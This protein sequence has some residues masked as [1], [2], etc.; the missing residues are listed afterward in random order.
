[1]ATIV[2]SAV[3]AA[4]GS[5]LLPEGIAILG[6]TITGATIGS[7]IGGS[8]GNMIDQSL[9]AGHRNIRT[10][11]PRQS[12]LR[13]TGSTEG[14]AVPRLFGRMRTGGQIIWATRFKETASTTSQSAGGKGFGG[15]GTTVTQTNYSYSISFAI[16]LC[17]GPISGI[18]RVWADGKPLDLSRINYRLH[19]GGEDQLPD[20]TIEA[21]E[22][23]NATPAYRGL[24][25]LVFDDLALE[26]FGNRVPQISVEVFGQRAPGGVE[27][28]IR[29]VDLIPASGEFTYATDL[30]TRT[31]TGA[32]GPGA[33]V[34]GH[35]EAENM[36]NSIGQPDIIVALDQLEQS[37]PNCKAVAL[38]ISWFGDDLR[39]GV[40]RV[41]PGVESRDKL[42]SRSWSVA[43]MT[44]GSAYLVTQQDGRAI[45][46]GTPSDDT[47]METIA[48][49]KKRGIKIVFYPFI[50]MDIPPETRTDDP[51]GRAFQPPY[52][53]RGRITCMPAP[54]QPATVDGTSAAVAD[55]EA[56][57]WGGPDNWNFAHMIGHYASLCAQAGGVDAFLVGSEL[58]GLT[59]V[60]GPG[61]SYPAVGALRTL[62]ATVKGYLPDTKVSYAADWTEWNNHQPSD[63][64][65]TLRFHLDPLWS[66]PVIDFIAIDN[67][68]PLSDWRDGSDHLDALAGHKSLY[69]LSYLKANVQGGERYDWY[70]ASPADRDAQ[71]RTPITD[72]AYGKPWVYRPKDLWNWWQQPHFE[73]TGGIEHAA[74]TSWVPESKPIVLTE[75]GCPAIDKGTNQP[76][77]FVDPKSS[78][79]FVPYYSSGRRDDLIQ[80]RYI[81]A[82]TQ[83]FLPESGLN[84]VSSVYGGRMIPDEGIFFWCWDARPFPDFPARSEIW[85]DTINWRL[86]HWLTGRMGQPGIGPV[87]EALAQQAGVTGNISGSIASLVS[88]YLIDRIMSPRQALETLMLAYRFD[89]A[90]RDG[91]FVLLPRNIPPVM[92]IKAEDLVE[93]EATDDTKPGTASYRIV[94]KQETDL[95][96]VAKLSYIDAGGDYRRAAAEVRR[97]AGTAARV[98]TADFALV[99]DSGEAEDIA[100]HMLTEAWGGREELTFRLP[101]TL[102]ALEPGDTIMF[103]DGAISRPFRIERVDD[104]ADRTVTLSAAELEIPLKPPAR[105][106]LRPT[107]AIQ[108]YAPPVA[109]ILDLPVLT[110]G[111]A[112]GTP[113][114]AAFAEPWPGGIAFHR[115]APG[116]SFVL[117]GVSSRPAVTGRLVG[118][119]YTGPLH[120]WDRVNS[121]WVQL[122]SGQLASAPEADVFAGS[123]LV[124]IGGSHGEWELV[125]FQQAELLAPLK[126]RLTHLLRGQFGTEHAMPAQHPAGT[127]FVLIDA[128]VEQMG[129]SAELRGAE[130][131]WRIGP[132]TRPVDDASMAALTLP[133]KAVGLRPYSPCHLKAR[134]LPG[135]DLQLSWTRRTRFGGDVWDTA[136]VPLHEDV[137][138]YWV[139]I[140][141]GG[142]LARSF[143]VPEARWLYAAE[144]QI[145]DGGVAPLRPFTIR[146]CQIS[147]RY[148]L[149][150]ALEAIVTD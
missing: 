123:N 25:Y 49:L 5:A 67:Y 47:V 117:E 74:P 41:K 71:V 134:R 27:D 42:V 31:Q 56:F 113:R 127:R 46:G 22:G 63:S 16:G 137:E 125:Q 100:D 62:A 150:I 104:G 90:E 10:E 40:C 85:T 93:A 11:G 21:V 119:L 52:P 2:L 89:I 128:T 129:L 1:M 149:G 29:G 35:A 88:G 38:A 15:G 122:N 112:E 13:L 131:S 109:A 114:A 139:E 110:Q 145:A 143:E 18:G 54:G 102:L 92:T 141:V 105:S 118:A 30:V 33:D 115:Q 64:P 32:A 135:E 148:G 17:E 45:Y 84:P 86:G 24:A 81:E 124:A 121:L 130:I 82:I 3:G 44:R 94:R 75:A 66:D 4:I 97:L 23:P 140:F 108:V 101:P 60:R 61:G 76:N 107:P 142:T 147:R 57:F 73:R 50:M 28:L 37:L 68:M 103:D 8:I 69:D 91:G 34:E 70:Y 80:R 79:S 106:V 99:L 98:A 95:P 12:D 144:D 53:W 126:Y 116:G 59:T 83:S 120:R 6:T 133:Y 58:V 72:G 48:E 51:Y 87:A 9:L 138:A 7:A 132:V 65:G 55:L 146:I 136:E 43:G 36:N 77:V 19:R 39:A 14:T 78:E 96:Q 111:E 20:P 26:A